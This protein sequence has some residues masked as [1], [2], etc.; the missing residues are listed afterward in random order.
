MKALREAID[1]LA[2]GADGDESEYSENIQPH[3]MRRGSMWQQAPD[4]R[5]DRQLGRP[6]AASGSGAQGG[7]VGEKIATTLAEEALKAAV[8]ALFL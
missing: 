2:K 7:G 4:E 3:E 5:H 1:Q 8:K 6:V